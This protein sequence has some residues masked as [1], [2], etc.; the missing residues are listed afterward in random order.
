MTPDRKPLIFWKKTWLLT[1]NHVFYE[2]NTNAKGRKNLKCLW[3]FLDVFYEK[4]KNFDDEVYNFYNTLFKESKSGLS[5]LTSHELEHWR[6]KNKGDDDNGNALE[7]AHDSLVMDNL[8][9]QYQTIL[10]N[11]GI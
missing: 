8:P 1:E 4:I 3:I 10:M 11:Y 5:S 9:K 2:K 7:G 6:R